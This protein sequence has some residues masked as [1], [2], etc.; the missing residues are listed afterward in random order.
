MNDILEFLEGT[1]IVEFD[2]KLAQI[3]L[4]NPENDWSNKIVNG[5]GGE[6]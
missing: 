3:T 2:E 4:E 5:I 1:E 6:E